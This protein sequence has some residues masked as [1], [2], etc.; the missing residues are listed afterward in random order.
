MKTALR[1]PLNFLRFK[2]LSIEHVT[3]LP[4]SAEEHCPE[5]QLN[6]DNSNLQGKST[7][8]QVR[9]IGS[10]SYQGMGFLLT[11]RTIITC[12]RTGRTGMFC[13]PKHQETKEIVT[14]NNS[15]LQCCSFFGK[16]FQNKFI[17]M[18]CVFSHYTLTNDVRVI[19]GSSY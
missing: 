13:A 14:E 15:K 11:P 3:K 1:S 12:I 9:V 19:E 5:I 16:L 18:E 7:K 6:P 8:V 10:S 2:L 17:V 4:S